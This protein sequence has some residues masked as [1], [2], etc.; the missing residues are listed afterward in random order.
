MGAG[1]QWSEVYS[2][3][4][5]HNVSVAGG[6]S[7]NGTVGAAAGWALGGGHSVLSPFF[8]LGT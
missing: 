8:G 6:F 3:A 4:D 2:A 5:A 1:V 7:P